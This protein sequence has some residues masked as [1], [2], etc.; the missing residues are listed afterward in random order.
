[1]CAAESMESDIKEKLAQET[2]KM[3]AQMLFVHS[4]RRMPSKEGLGQAA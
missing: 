2:C 3:K 1:M 4:N